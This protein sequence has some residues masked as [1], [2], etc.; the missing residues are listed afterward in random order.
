MAYLK[1]KNRSSSALAADI[2]DAATSL[3]VTT[4]EG[5]KFPSSG[6]FNITIEDEI[7]KCTARST[8]T[9]T[10]TRAQETTTAAAHAAGISVELRITAGVLESR[11]TW[12][13]GKLKRGAGDGV[14]PTEIDV[15]A[16]ATTVYKTADEIVNN[17]TTLQ[18][19]DH[20]LLAL[21]ANE[22]WRLES[23]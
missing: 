14:D 9:L 3:T 20:L 15:P 13:E 18:N 19:D 17:S 5:A 2:T 6:D 11:D 1:I 16:A 4:G 22:V 10:V 21:G 23:C 7:L 12:T 8:D